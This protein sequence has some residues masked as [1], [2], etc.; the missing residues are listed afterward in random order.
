[1]RIRDLLNDKAVLLKAKPKTKEEAINLLVDLLV[2]SDCINNADRFRRAVFDRESKGSTGL[3]EGVA[4]PHAKS[5]SVVKPGLAAMVVPSGVDFESLDGKDARLF[6]LIASPHQASNDHVDVLA[7]L[8]TLLIDENFRNSLVNSKTV[9]EFLGYIDK[10]EGIEIEHEQEK[11]QASQSQEQKSDDNKKHV[12]QY[13]LVAV[14]A[15]PAGL[16][17]TY[18]AAESIEHCAHEM[19]LSI[20]VEADGAAGNRNRLLPEDIANA[21][22]VIV[23]AD[24]MVEMDRFIGKPLVRVGVVSGIRMPDRLI[25][26]A[27]DPACPIYTPGQM[28]ESSSFLMR[29]YRHLMSG[30][31]YIMPLAAT[32]GILSAFSRQ[33]WLQGSNLGI[34]LDSIGYSLGTLLFP[35]L[36]AFIAFSIAGRMALVAGFIGGV[37]ADLGDAGV[38]GA[39]IN[40]FLGGGVAFLSSRFGQRFLKG[41]D[42]MIALLVYPLLGAL[43]TTLIAQF[44]TNL[45]AAFIN[46]QIEFMLL[47]APIF[48]ITILGAILG[49]MMSADMGGPCNKIAYA[50]G[51]L[52]LADCL[53]E[54]Q[55]GG[56][57]MAAVMAGG[58]VPPLAAGLAS[59]I[60]RKYFTR[61]ERNIALPTLMKGLFFITEGV[62]PYLVYSPLRMRI[63]CICGSA[64]AGALSVFFGCALCAPHG[65]IFIIPISDNPLDFVLSLTAGTLLGAFLFIVLRIDLKRFG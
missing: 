32:A 64:T 46:G 6:F 22:A 65:G 38:I 5:V 13:D 19:G 11:A 43:G 9:S 39:V 63:A 18:M 27:L 8:S 31:T 2:N 28:T 24:R 54:S 33:T 50:S 35:V 36:G 30:L 20:K 57:I 45:P 26:K 55:P 59:L 47:H 14:T 3:G 44:I 21:K 16:S 23:A 1:M 40:G 62:L 41:H 42:A 48:I 10:A 37:M 25:A 60:A 4:I 34:F 58:M 29:L 49:G 12:R 53:P 61:H 52:L 7:R 56:Q 15:C 51:V 17:H